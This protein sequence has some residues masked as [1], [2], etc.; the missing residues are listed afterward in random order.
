MNGEIVS[1]TSRNSQV[2]IFIIQL[3]ILILYLSFSLLDGK[4]GNCFCFFK[5]GNPE[6]GLLSLGFSFS[7][8]LKKGRA[9]EGG[10]D[11][12]LIFMGIYSML[13][14]VLR[15]LYILTLLV[16]MPILCSEY[17]YCPV[18][19]EIKPIHEGEFAHLVCGQARIRA[20]VVSL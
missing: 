9:G 14:T 3:N 19:Q 2:R 8:S 10:E 4:W 1:E 20:Q 12:Q 6:W 15:T 11:N 5:Y 18:S 16:L 13:G 7:I 17:F